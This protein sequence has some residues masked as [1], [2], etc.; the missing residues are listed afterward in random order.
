MNADRIHTDPCTM[1]LDGILVCCCTC[2][3][4]FGTHHC[5]CPKCEKHRPT[6]EKP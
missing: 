4:C 1:L 3:D 5:T 2:P 6:E